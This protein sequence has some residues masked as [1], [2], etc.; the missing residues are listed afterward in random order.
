MCVKGL[1]INN[2]F[3]QEQLNSVREPLKITFNGDPVEKLI[4][5]IKAEDWP[6][7]EA[8]LEV[9]LFSSFVV[10]ISSENFF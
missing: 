6:L 4:D 5:T 9:S 7:A 8:G 10:Y 2:D 3:Q 1:F